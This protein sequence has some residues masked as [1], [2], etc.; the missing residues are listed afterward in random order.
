MQLSVNFTGI[1]SVNVE[2]HQQKVTVWGIC[3]KLDVLSMVKNKRK[4]ARFWECED[5]VEMQESH[6]ASA[7]SSPQHSSLSIKNSARY[8]AI[9]KRQS[10]NFSVSMIKNRSMNWKA[11]KKV[12]TRSNSF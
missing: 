2:F 9:I 4:G 1:Y 11:I 10:L 3:D 5:H 6:S 12:F 7:P 8:L